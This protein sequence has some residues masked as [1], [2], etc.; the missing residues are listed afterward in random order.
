MTNPMDD[1]MITIA[2]AARLI[3]VPVTTARGWA[4]KGVHV[5]AVHHGRLGRLV[6][7]RSEVERVLAERERAVERRLAR[8]TP[9]TDRSTDYGHEHAVD[10]GQHA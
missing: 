10:E 2:E 4:L 7:P 8:W 6:V 5:G 1:D 9:M 3:G